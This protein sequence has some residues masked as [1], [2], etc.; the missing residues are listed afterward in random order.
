MQ[1]CSTTT[2][3]S[4]WALTIKQERTNIFLRVCS[5]SLLQA[6]M[7]YSYGP[8]SLLLNYDLWTV[9]ADNR[10]LITPTYIN[11]NNFTLQKGPQQLSIQSAPGTA[12]SR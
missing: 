12:T 7:P 6:V 1:Q 2:S 5:A 11:A 8:D 10:L 4:I 3:I 9:A